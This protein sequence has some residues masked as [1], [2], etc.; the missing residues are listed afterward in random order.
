[1][2]YVRLTNP[3]WPAPRYV[4]FSGVTEDQITAMYEAAADGTTINFIDAATFAAAVP[5]PPKPGG[6]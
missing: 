3:A 4:K 1:M 6:T 2:L 5:A